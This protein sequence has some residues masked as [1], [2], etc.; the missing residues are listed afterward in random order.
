MKYISVLFTWLFTLYCYGQVRLDADGLG[1]TYNLITS[2]LAPGY[3]PI[4]VPDCGHEDFGDH[5]DELFDADLNAN[6]FRFYMHVTPDNDRCRNFDR[7]R[8]EIKSYSKSPDNL[9]G[10]VGEQVIYKWKFKLT[11][12]FQSSPN[13]T[14][15]HQLK[16]V[17][18]PFDGMPMYTL[19]TRKGS[20]DRLELR[21]A[22]IDTQITLKKTDLQPFIGTWLEV[23]E[24]IEYGTSG[25][26]S[27]E[28]KR[29]S[30]G[31][32]LFEYS[33]N[34][35]VHW[36]Q[37]AEFVRPKWGIYRSL[38]N[39]QDLRDEQ[40]LF[41]NFSIEEVE[42]LSLDVLEPK[43]EFCVV[44]DSVANTLQLY[45]LPRE[46]KHIEVYTIDGRKVLRKSI[47][48]AKETLYIPSLSKGT[49]IIKVTG[50]AMNQSKKIEY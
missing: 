48:K 34:D 43:H 13:F 15:L 24:V 40:V 19:T 42:P 25:A 27:I 16:S 22:E 10:V 14:H 32:V 9:L 23:S 31:A 5:I 41:A 30:D 33:N 12:G 39:P 50:G 26:Y 2:V 44:S 21:Y 8:N 20:P 18:G 28:I 17:G 37:D 45:N 49:Y 46:A 29:V 6:V 1:N 7:Q 35:M 47:R 3:N 36:R 38:N 4:E 11:D